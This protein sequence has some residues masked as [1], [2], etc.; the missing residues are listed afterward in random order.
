[1][2]VNRVRQQ[3]S[4]DSF[5]KGGPRLRWACRRRE[6]TTTS[7][8]ITISPISTNNSNR[9]T[10]HRS[11]R[12][13]STNLSYIRRRRTA[14]WLPRI[15]LVSWRMPVS[16]SKLILSFI[17]SRFLEVPSLTVFQLAMIRRH[18]TCRTS[19]VW[20]YPSRKIL[21]VE[22]STFWEMLRGFLQSARVYL[23]IICSPIS[24]MYFVYVKKCYLRLEWPC[25]MC[26]YYGQP[27]PFVTYSSFLHENATT[28]II[29]I[30]RLHQLLAAANTGKKVSA[31]PCIGAIRHLCDLKY[32][33]FMQWYLR[34]RLQRDAIS[35]SSSSPVII[36][37]S[38]HMQ[39]CVKAKL[40]F[41]VCWPRQVRQTRPYK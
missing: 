17:Y 13:Y 40:Y 16:R 32:N 18:A 37:P 12:L 28:T 20:F 36:R 26:A 24:R 9:I 39:L 7:L 34:A 22:R 30:H 8:I 1:M 21:S 33:M 5:H 41:R 14:Q 31:L 10:L 11:I 29:M 27:M 6:S 35:S 4:K 23:V 15:R 19:L 38:W 3:A 2:S 25:G